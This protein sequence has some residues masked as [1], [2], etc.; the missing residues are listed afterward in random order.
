MISV[1]L[2]L[3]C[4]VQLYYKVSHRVS[5]RG[6]EKL[7]VCG[8]YIVASNHI[9]NHDP[10][11]LAAFLN[12]NIKFMAKKELFRVPVLRSIV[13]RLD[14]F[15]VHRNGIGIGAI[16]HAIRL[17]NMGQTVGIFPE[18]T[19]NRDGRPIPYKPGVGFIATRS[20]CAVIVPVAICA[21]QRRFFRSFHIVVGD[22]ITP[23]D[24]DYRLLTEHVM[25]AINGL[26]NS[27]EFTSTRYVIGQESIE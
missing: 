1:R 7:P 24:S 9:S 18:G 17:L 5:V 21:Q 26:K 27:M 3:K 10:I 4:V 2:F 8:P 14:A 23:L 19:R 15:P 22:P 16:R 25:K 12:H 20:N 11:L 13:K 6:L